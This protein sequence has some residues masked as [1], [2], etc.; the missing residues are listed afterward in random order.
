MRAGVRI[1]LG[2]EVT[3]DLLRRE[4]PQVLVAATGSEPCGPVLP[5][6]DGPTIVCAR[7]VMAGLVRL[8]VGR[9]LVAGGGTV[10]L[11]VAEIAAG[12]GASVTVVEAREE[13]G[14]DMFAEAR[15]LLLA[16]LEK[17]G[18]RILVSTSLVSVFPGGAVVSRDGAPAE[19][20]EGFDSIISALGAQPLDVL[21]GPAAE[22]GIEV[23]VVG[24]ARQ[25]RQA[26]A[27]IAEGFEAGRSIQ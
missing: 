14:M 13:V 6:M 11:E 15:V 9:L 24:D 17:L 16:K 3:S 12:A 19:R 2:R 26:V 7:E 25:P 22:A 18:V 21:S 20:I 27:A 23:H 10:G 1:H 4:K 5:G 8:P